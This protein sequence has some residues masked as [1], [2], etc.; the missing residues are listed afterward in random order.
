VKKKDT[1][2]HNSGHT[3][4]IMKSCVRGTHRVGGSFQTDRQDEVPGVVMRGTRTLGHGGGLKT[5]C[6]WH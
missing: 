5:M 6:K 3:G 2:G 1:I 4:V